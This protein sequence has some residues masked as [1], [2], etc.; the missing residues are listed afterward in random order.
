MSR[1]LAA[2]STFALLFN[3]VFGATASFQYYRFTPV[4]LRNGAAANSVQMSELQLFLGATQRTG[5]QVS[6]P[7]GNNPGNEGP[8]NLVD[9]NTN[10][11]WLDFN[12]NPVILNYGTPVV[13]D[14]YRW[15]TANDANERDPIR[16][17]LEGSNDGTSWTLMDDRS[18]ADQAVSNNR[19]TFGS[20][21]D[22]N[23]LPDTPVVIFDVTTESGVVSGAAVGIPAGQTVT[24]NWSTTGA[25]SVTLNGSPV[26]ANSSQVVSPVSTTSYELVATNG[27]GSTIK[28]ITVYLGSSFA[29]PLMNEFAAQQSRDGVLCDEDGDASD[30]I[31]LYN[32]NP[33][34]IDAGGFYLTDDIA[35]VTKWQLPEGS[36][37]EPEGF[38]IVFASGK[39]RGGEV[40]HASFSLGVDGE[41]LAILANDGVTVIE[42]FSPT[43]PPQIEDVS[44]GRTGGG[45]DFFTG[46]TPN[47]V[48][49]T[50]PGAP[51]GPVVF[52]TPAGTFSGSRLVTLSTLSAGA[53]IRYT[54]DGT[55]PDA[56]SALYSA[57][58]NL[59]NSAFVR[60]RTFEAGLAP[61]PVKAEAYLLISGSASSQTSDLP[62]VVIDNFGAGNV[63]NN[64]DLQSAYFTLF[65]PNVA[66]GRTSL[67]DLP[68]KANRAGI[69]RRGSSTLNDPKGNYRIEFWQDDSEM[70]RSINLLG[71]SDHDEWILFAP[72]NFDRSLLRIP[73]LHTLSNDIGTYAPKTRFV[74][75]YL[76]T[77][78]SVS[79]ADYQ[80][81]YVLQE[82]ISR[83]KDRVDIDRLDKNDTS[84]N[85]VTGGY[86]LSIDRLDSS[87]RGF[88]SALGHPFDPPN[89]SPQPWFTYVYPK[90]QN[91]LPEQASYI[92]GY[93]DDFESSLYGPNF[94]DPDI[95]YQAWFD[96]KAS[97]DHHI[98]TTF[99]KDPDG[100]RLSTYLFKPRGGKL[101]FGPIWDFDRT[102]GSDGDGRSSDPTGWNP[103]PERAEFFDY[104]YWGR[105]F[106]DE[107]F[108]QAWIDRWQELR[109]GQFAN[110]ALAARLDGLATEVT[111]SQPRNTARWPEVAPNGGPLTNLGGWPGEVDHLKNWV[112][113][114]ADWIDTQFVAPPNLQVNSLIESG[115][116]V[117]ASAVEGTLYYT[118]DGSD[119]RLPGGAISPSATALG[120]L[121]GITLD[122]TTTITVRARQAGEWSGPLQST[123]VVGV[124]ASAS[125]IVVSEIMYHPAPP[126]VE[127]M[128]AGF[129]EDSDFEFLELQNISNETVVLSGA[130]FSD[131]FDLTITDSI[132][133]P[134]AV[135]VV[136]RNIAGFQKRYGISIPIAGEYGD[137]SLAD[138]GQ[139]LS[140]GGEEIILTGVTGAVIQSFVYN[141]D[142]L[143]GWPSEPDGS[144][145][146]LVLRAP[147]TGPDHSLPA[148]WRAGLSNFGTPG[149]ATDNIFVE[150]SSDF[151]NLGELSD[152]NISGPNADPDGDG[153]ENLL[154]MAFG[155]DPGVPSDGLQPVASIATFAVD[156]PDPG[157]YYTLSV[158]RRKNL[159]GVMLEAKF[160]PDLE[161][162]S[163][164]GIVQSITDLGNGAER[165]IYRDLLPLTPSK[166]RKF[167]RFEVKIQ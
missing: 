165:V 108:M 66:T 39:N 135:A 43:Y 103:A 139:N 62:I 129:L 84:G 156:V 158:T 71:M 77:S 19:N 138:G 162:W 47:A 89:G 113:Q 106:D 155:G 53:E 10:T 68:T 128:N 145:V 11:K 97:I 59:T 134:G 57:P 17:L 110:S 122:E 54:V 133:A 98:L 150:W 24:L 23:Q 123:F 114:R 124:P 88:R 3:T 166:P 30:W 109:R 12:R 83:D 140:N 40:L 45:Y 111:E 64:V 105:L 131:V 91:I 74:E 15:A 87:D 136:V 161:E 112:T 5:A 86:I 149:L 154:E 141:D 69:K 85:E 34:A 95:G 27:F 79:S 55:I 56:A 130:T 82:R 70:D 93:I 60:A 21:L 52:E 26:A 76:N 49:D 167:A 2:I 61:G 46:P 146:S 44:Y 75:L 116:A 99:S 8:N 127:E 63:P 94:K 144:G 25:D 148:S 100:L 90:E 20:A 153:I 51:G 4:K 159:A 118:I 120:G 6:N 13:V 152:S 121:A 7:G 126:T 37:I 101:G 72:Y 38:L 22:F 32:P 14:S 81:V 107:N 1:F 29:P 96:V 160:S 137:S 119:P 41:Y 42:E 36:V 151:F 164:S 142:P 50:T 143:A 33:F 35:H 16:W 115:E 18:D 48:N 65:E 9:N 73:F 28:S 157:D 125:N 31:E 163:Q 117:V 92:Q 58:I 102:M 132:L 147:L 104:D 80:G 67:E 78:G